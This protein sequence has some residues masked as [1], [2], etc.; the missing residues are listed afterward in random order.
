MKWHRIL[1]TGLVILGACSLSRTRQV[2]STHNARVDIHDILVRQF[3]E[4]DTHI[5]RTWYSGVFDGE[6]TVFRPQGVVHY[7]PD[8]GLRGAMDEVRMY[9][10]RAQVVDSTYQNQRTVA[11]HTTSHESAGQFDTSEYSVSETVQP[12]PMFPKW[13][14]VVLVFVIG[15]WLFKKFR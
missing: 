13:G 7:H 4:R 15:I 12:L 14:Y 6:L 5:A 3:A 11:F 8:S 9:S 2:E 10:G 1:W